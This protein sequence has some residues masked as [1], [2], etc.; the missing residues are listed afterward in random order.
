MNLPTL[1]FLD[2]LRERIIG[3]SRIMLGLLL[4]QHGTIKHLGIPESPMN[5]TT[6]GSASGI[7][8]A[9]E[10][11]VGATFALGYHT[12]LSAFV[13][14]GLCAVAYFMVHAGRSFFP[15]LNGGELA[16]VYSFAFIVMAVVGPGAWSMDAKR[17]DKAASGA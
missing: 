5:A 9:I 7:A 16:A 6:L 1:P 17:A 13:L 11:I 4:M 8:G 2:P 12:R 15:I 10:L 14:S 3:G